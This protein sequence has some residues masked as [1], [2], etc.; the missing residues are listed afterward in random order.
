M[1]DADRREA[2]AVEVAIKL[3]DRDMK[4]VSCGEE[5]REVIEL[6]EKMKKKVLRVVLAAN[7]GLIQKFEYVQ[8]EYVLLLFLLLL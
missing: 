2:I 8:F 4:D 3:Y 1:K 6:I 5:E 7:V